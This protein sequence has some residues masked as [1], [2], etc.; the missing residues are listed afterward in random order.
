MCIRQK[1]SDLSILL[2]SLSLVFSPFFCKWNSHGYDIAKI[3]GNKFTLIS[4]VWLQVKRRGKERFQFTGLHDADKGVISFSLVM[5][6]Q[7]RLLV[8]FQTK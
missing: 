5:H 7:V 4:P 1:E 6:L 3:F 8:L 2:L